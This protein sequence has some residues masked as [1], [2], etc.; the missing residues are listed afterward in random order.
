MV[1]R[2]VNY[3]GFHPYILLGQF[4]SLR[5]QLFLHL[6]HIQLWSISLFVIALIPS[7]TQEPSDEVET[8]LAMILLEIIAVRMAQVIFARAF[9]SKVATVG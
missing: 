1:Q 3:E 6:I 4:N 8:V 5:I 7:I 2:C 9:S